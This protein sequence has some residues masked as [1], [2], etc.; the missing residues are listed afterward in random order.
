MI[1][2]IQKQTQHADTRSDD[3]SHKNLLKIYHLKKK[4]I[5]ILHKKK[6][7]SSYIIFPLTMLEQHIYL[8]VEIATTSA[9]TTM[10]LHTGEEK[11]KRNVSLSGS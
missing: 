8:K 5:G 11:P 10:A 9:L 4:E 2:F 3:G 7:L 1:D 6:F